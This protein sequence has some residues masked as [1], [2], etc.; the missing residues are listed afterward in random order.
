MADCNQVICV[1]EWGTDETYNGIYPKGAREKDVYYSPD[2]PSFPCLRSQHRYL[3]KKSFNRYPWQFWMEIIAY[4]VG[5]L[6]GVEVPPAYVGL[7]HRGEDAQ[8]EYG[9]LI[10]WFY[11]TPGSIYVD[12]SSFMTRAIENYDIRRGSQHNIQTIFEHVPKGVLLL[13]ELL[14]ETFSKSIATELSKS[15][16]ESFKV[17]L[18]A[19][20]HLPSITEIQHELISYWADI[21]CFDTII[22]NTDRHQD[23]WGWIFTLKTN[24]HVVPLTIEPQLVV[25]V[26][27]TAKPSPAFDNGTALNHEIIEENFRRFESES[28]LNNYISKPTRAKHHMKWN[29]DDSESVNFYEFMKRYILKFPFV[30]DQV[31]KR[32][33]FSRFDLEERLSALA[34]ILEEGANRLTIR[35]LEFI[36]N[37]ITKR[38]ELLLKAIDA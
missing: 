28:Y 18:D 29:L 24:N 17:I 7:R 38:R 4:R 21:L 34:L 15:F 8:D 26:S 30:K 32:L 5:Q 23:N 22:G 12:G 10:E 11:T 19:P 9:A 14:S 20:K 25:N 27:V 13:W 37:M 36:I 1:D 6:M 35:R 31:V 3:L 16:G 33:T 2:H